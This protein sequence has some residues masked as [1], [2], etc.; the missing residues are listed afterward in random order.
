LE[1]EPV[2]PGDVDPSNI[3]GGSGGY[4]TAAALCRFE[5]KIADAANGSFTSI[6]KVSPKIVGINSG[7]GMRNRPACLRPPLE[8]Q[9]NAFLRWKGA[10]G[11]SEF[12]EKVGRRF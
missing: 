3:K 8:K 4:S 1:G 12:S 2:G 9:L 11:R 6:G 10:I 5:G 7:S